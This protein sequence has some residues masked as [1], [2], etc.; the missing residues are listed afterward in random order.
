[1][2]NVLQA[3]EAGFSLISDDQNPASNCEFWVNFAA[4]VTIGGGYAPPGSVVPTDLLASS[5]VAN[6]S[7]NFAS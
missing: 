1:M 6:A 3:R 2:S 5:Y 7:V 4:A